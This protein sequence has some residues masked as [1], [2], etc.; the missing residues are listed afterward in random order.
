MKYFDLI[1]DEC[2]RLNDA[3]ENTFPSNLKFF[4]GA[5]L[6]EI[7]YGLNN[8]YIVFCYYPERYD[9]GRMMLLK[10]VIIR[11]NYSGERR[12]SI[13]EI[14]SF[15]Q[16][17]CKRYVA[18]ERIPSLEDFLNLVKS[19]LLFE[20]DSTNRDWE[21]KFIAYQKSITDRYR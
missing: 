15:L 3:L 12:Y 14:T 4:M 21:E 8:D 11:L 10:D 13:L 1:F 5:N 7:V 17:D 18:A 6:H 2:K 16:N 20:F 9:Y 19:F